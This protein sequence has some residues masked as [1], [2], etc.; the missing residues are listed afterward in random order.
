M[1]G[2]IFHNL[3]QTAAA[4]LV[5]GTPTVAFYLPALLLSAVIT[6]TFTGLAAQAAIIRM[7]KK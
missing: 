1:F 6:G 5:Y 7:G 2:A 4:I 3:G